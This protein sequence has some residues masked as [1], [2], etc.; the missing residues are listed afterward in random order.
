MYALKKNVFFLKMSGKK[1]I[2]PSQNKFNKIRNAKK[3]FHAKRRRKKNTWVLVGFE[4]M[5]RLHQTC[6]YVRITKP[7]DSMADEE[8]SKSFHCIGFI[9]IW[10]L[11]L[12]NLIDKYTHTIIICWSTAQILPDF[13]FFFFLCILIQKK[14]SG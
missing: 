13:F 2:F 10:N 12:F 1:I 9:L 4:A 6:L 5:P 7:Y 11:I 8:T 14:T 3:K